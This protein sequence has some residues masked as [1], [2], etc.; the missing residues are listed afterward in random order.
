MEAVLHIM[1]YLKLMHKSMIA[2][3]LSDSNKGDS[4]F[5]EFDW[6]DF[7]EG[8]VEAIPSNAPLLSGK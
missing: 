6:K 4:E 1:G 3:D 7:Y 2:F 5:W 8:T